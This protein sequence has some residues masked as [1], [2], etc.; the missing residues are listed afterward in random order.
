MDGVGDRPDLWPFEDRSLD[1][2]FDGGALE[3]NRVGAE[4]SVV[5][6]GVQHR[7][8]HAVDLGHGVGMQPRLGEAAVPGA[9]GGGGEVA[10]FDALEVGED[11]G[12][13]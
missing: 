9:E 7:P 13:L 2:S 8:E 10:Q 11:V 5:H 1:G 4:E 6:G 3:M 12:E